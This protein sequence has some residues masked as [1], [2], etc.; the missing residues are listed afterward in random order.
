MEVTYGEG[1]ARPNQRP[2]ADAAPVAVLHD[3]ES[4]RLGPASE[5]G[6]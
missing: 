4:A 3:F 1:V 5:G 6:R 2:A